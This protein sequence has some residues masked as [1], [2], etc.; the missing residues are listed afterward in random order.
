M[1]K[2]LNNEMETLQNFMEFLDGLDDN[3]L[4]SW[5]IA[6]DRFRITDFDFSEIS[7]EL[8]KEIYRGTEI[9]RGMSKFAIFNT[10]LSILSVA[11]GR[12]TEL[13]STFANKRIKPSVYIVNVAKSSQGKSP[14][15]D[16]IADDTIRRRAD[17]IG[18][19][20]DQ[21]YESINSEDS[22]DREALE[23][24]AVLKQVQPM[25]GDYTLPAL[26]QR[27]RNSA[28][29]INFDE[30]GIFWNT[31]APEGKQSLMPQ[32]TKLFTGGQTDVSRVGPGLRD[33]RDGA[34]SVYAHGTPALAKKFFS[35]EYPHDGT[36]YRFLF[37]NSE[38]SDPK[39][40][41]KGGA[42]A[43]LNEVRPD[44]GVPTVFIEIFNKVFN[45]CFM[46]EIQQDADEPIVNR[47]NRN[48]YVYNTSGASMKEL[49][50]VSI[51]RWMEDQCSE[52]NDKGKTVKTVML[53]KIH[54][55]I[56]KLSLLFQIMKDFA[57]DNNI[58]EVDIFA[59]AGRGNI[60]DGKSVELAFNYMR[61]MYNNWLDLIGKEV[62]GEASIDDIAND[63]KKKPPVEVK[64]L[65]EILKWVPGAEYAE[66]EVMSAIEGLERSDKNNKTKLKKLIVSAKSANG[67]GQKTCWVYFTTSG[68]I[69]INEWK[70]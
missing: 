55:Y 43:R 2:K 56:D 44:H 29:L 18:Y 4:K 69:K 39:K 34:L 17:D 16:W 27:L 32:L 21:K 19:A 57:P 64:K 38:G 1:E 14:M 11:C 5:H 46:L 35:G 49:A 22:K 70:S 33:V 53:S 52:S 24:T 59:D 42:S 51:L 10:M 37:T 20:F 65:I 23:R 13:H 9:H 62:I 25:S 54:N 61:I 60:V 41:G 12:Y 66:S 50:S 48:T 28:V 68:K 45:S 63:E 3:D 31:N 6:E 47:K 67:T 30:L 7:P 26:L 40:Y 8:A 58:K 36:S 15:F